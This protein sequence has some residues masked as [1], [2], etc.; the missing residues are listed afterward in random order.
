MHSKEIIMDIKDK[1]LVKTKIYT[2][3][4]EKPYSFSEFMALASTLPTQDVTACLNTI[5]LDVFLEKTAL[6]YQNKMNQDVEY[7]YHYCDYIRLCYR[8]FSHHQF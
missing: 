6:K 4:K 3:A 1:E 2:L 7:F 5:V 8:E